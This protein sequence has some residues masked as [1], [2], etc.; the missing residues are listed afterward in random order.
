MARLLLKILSIFLILYSFSCKLSDK[1]PQKGSSIN[2]GVESSTSTSTIN[3]SISTTKM[4]PNELSFSNLKVTSGNYESECFEQSKSFFQS[5][6]IIDNNIIVSNLKEYKDSSCS[7][8]VSI[9]TK[10]RSLSSIESMGQFQEG[11]YLFKITLLTRKAHLSLFK[12]DRVDYFN[13]LGAY[14]NSSWLLG[15]PQ[16]ISSR[17][18]LPNNPKSVR[19]PKNQTSI[20]KYLLLDS[21]SLSIAIVDN[22][23][24]QDNDFHF[25]K[26]IQ[27]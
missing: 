6:A 2:K 14:E 3:S 17:L 18:Q 24:N 19:E 5:Q 23:P 10:T 25:M 4:Q 7:D 22:S 9:T 21:N 13:Q 15:E 11:I 8:L 12:Q 20:N 1:H 26:K 27:N 16:D